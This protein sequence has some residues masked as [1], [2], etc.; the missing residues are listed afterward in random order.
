MSNRRKSGDRM[1]NIIHCQ[2]KNN[3]K[4]LNAYLYKDFYKKFIHNN[5]GFHI[6]NAFHFS[7]AIWYPFVIDIPYILTV[8]FHGVV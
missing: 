6:E 7:S 1:N 4:G 3:A 8:L 2:L 5:C